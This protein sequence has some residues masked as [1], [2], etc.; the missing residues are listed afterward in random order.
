[1]IL[2]PKVP[3]TGED[4]GHAMLGAGGDDLGVVSRAPGLNHGRDAEAGSDVD[5]VTEGEKWRRTP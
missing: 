2:M 1:M 5:A 3:A 4:H